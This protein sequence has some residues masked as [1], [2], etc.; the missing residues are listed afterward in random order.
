MHGQAATGQVGWVLLASAALVA[1]FAPV[2]AYLYG[3][4]G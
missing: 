1:V 2:T 4:Q 3:R